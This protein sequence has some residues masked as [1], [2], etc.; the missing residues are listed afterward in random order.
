MPRRIPS[1][2][3]GRLVVRRLVVRRA[4]DGRLQRQRRSRA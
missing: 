1:S 2:M 4:M 3:T